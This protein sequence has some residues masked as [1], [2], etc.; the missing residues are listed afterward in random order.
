MSRRHE[1]TIGWISPLPLEKE[2]AC[3]VFDEEYPQNEVN[4]KETFHTGGRTGHH[5]VV[6]GVQRKMGHSG[7]AVLAE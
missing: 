4:H 5:K 3:L 1:F 2:A 6:I 7:A